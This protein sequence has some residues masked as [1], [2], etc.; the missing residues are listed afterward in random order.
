MN[1]PIVNNA[2]RFV[3]WLYEEFLPDG[4][5]D[6]QLD[7][8]M[9]LKNY[10]VRLGIQKRCSEKELEILALAA[11]L[12]NTGCVEGQHDKRQV[13]KKIAE[14]FLLEQKYSSKA[15]QQV[16]FCIDHTVKGKT[17]SNRLAKI[18]RQAKFQSTFASRLPDSKLEIGD[19]WP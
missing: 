13:S 5:S 2:F 3:K 8:S 15:I 4:L 19:L 18:I 6:W 17:S 12:H 14:R 7:Q 11:L 16:L 9:E 10:T 1:T